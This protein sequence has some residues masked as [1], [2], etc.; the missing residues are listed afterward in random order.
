MKPVHLPLTALFS[1]V[2]SSLGPACDLKGD[3]APGDQNGSA[4]T[5][6]S[7]SSC[8]PATSPEQLAAI[9]PGTWTGNV[10][11]TDFTV[12]VE[13]T[14]NADG[15]FHYE[16]PGDSDID[17]TT[18]SDMDAVSE[19][20]AWRV[21]GP[22]LNMVSRANPYDGCGE[23]ERREVLQDVWVSDDCILTATATSAG[24]WGNTSLGVF[25]LQRN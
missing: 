16:F 18:C 7:G 10:Y 5:D 21:L 2:F 25:E 22:T 4:D 1:L 15:S 24:I 3:S 13:M 17:S 19:G 14:F 12:E 11:V 8:G 23:D 9:L 20:V 6:V